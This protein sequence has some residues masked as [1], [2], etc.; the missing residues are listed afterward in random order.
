MNVQQKIEELI[1]EEYK[2]VTSNM[3]GCKA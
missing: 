2:D 3:T 1:G